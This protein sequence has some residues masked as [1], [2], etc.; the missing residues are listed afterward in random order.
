MV[1]IIV[2]DKSVSKLEN[3]MAEFLGYAIRTDIQKLEPLH[4]AFTQYYKDARDIKEPAS[5]PHVNA[6][7]RSIP[8]TSTAIDAIA[9]RIINDI[10]DFDHPVDF[11]AVNRT[12][13]AMRDAR[14][15]FA[16][17]DLESNMD[18]KRQI[19]DF[20]WNSCVYGVSFMKTFFEEKK[21]WTEDE[22]FAY[23]LE[24]GTFI[25][26]QTD[27]SIV[28]V[29]NF[30]TESLTQRQIPFSTEAVKQKKVKWVRYHPGMYNI[31]VKNVLW[32]EDAVSLK[33]AF[34]NCNGVHER[35]YRT[36]DYLMKRMKHNKTG[37]YE[38]LTKVMIAE[39]EP[40]YKNLTSESERENF[41]ETKGKIRKIP[42]YE[43]YF[44]FDIDGDGENE[45]VAALYNLKS[46]K[47]I[48]FEKFTLLD[49]VP[50]TAGYIKKVPDKVVGAGIAEMNYDLKD[51]IDTTINNKV[52]REE[53]SGNPIIAYTKDSGFNP[54]V[55]K[56]GPQQT[57]LL[58]NIGES[59]LR[60]LDFAKYEGESY[61]FVNQMLT[62]VQKRTLVTDYTLGSESKIASNSTARG[63]EALINESNVGISYL[64][65]N[66]ILSVTEIFQ[67]RQDIYEKKW[68]RATE[69][70]IIK[71][72]K[73]WTEEI[74]DNPDN[75]W[76]M[77][78][79]EALR[80]KMNVYITASKQE[81]RS[82]MNKAQ[83]VLEFLEKDPNMQRY[84][85]LRREAVVNL[86]RIL[87]IKE[88]D[89]VYPSQEQ[90]REIAVQVETEAKKRIIAEQEKN[91]LA[92]AEE[93]GF[94]DGKAELKAKGE[95]V[96]LSEAI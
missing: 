32:P 6:S 31:D 4:N 30:M 68:G 38:D 58:N 49:R 84:P 24:D 71:L 40:E 43:C 28:E 50:I 83:I 65:N 73:E 91:A 27:G 82:A 69:P 77:Q 8:T 90:L 93:T 60:T 12:G 95:Q 85:E 17:W 25:T 29:N 54:A 9:P 55:N 86:F 47:V 10:F 2:N 16:D 23:K 53:Y 66:M 51:L 26:D 48:G 7:N 79:V 89:K 72:V 1:N 41:I 19:W 59:A 75:P 67:N 62:F 20:I 11:K 42:F 64:I 15:A 22:I 96:D 44:Q 88:A 61:N 45:P 46:N 36:A 92:D 18:M 81:N 14:K 35:V 57:W 21:G 80:Q 56:T 76:G 33:D 5:Y 3:E 78:T 70:E 13:Y 74:T 37:I 63:I 34:E 52:N 94:R 39:F 87:K